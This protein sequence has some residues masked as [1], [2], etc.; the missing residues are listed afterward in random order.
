MTVLQ[1][2]YSQTPLQLV[3]RC[4][5]LAHKTTRD[6]PPLQQWETKVSHFVFV[7]SKRRVYAF[8]HNTVVAAHPEVFWTTVWLVCLSVLREHSYESPAKKFP[9]PVCS[10]EQTLLT[11]TSCY[12]GFPPSPTKTRSDKASLWL[13][14]PHTVGLQVPS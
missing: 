6:K 3:E 12:L 10:V 4:E 13:S 14:L 11:N 2:P 5:R 1:L 8:H 7:A 9:A